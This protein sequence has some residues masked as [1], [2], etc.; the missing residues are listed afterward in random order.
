MTPARPVDVEGVLDGALHTEIDPHPPIY[1]FVCVLLEIV[2]NLLFGERR[3]GTVKFHV[4]FQY[5]SYL[6]RYDA[7]S[8]LG[9]ARRSCIFLLHI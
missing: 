7:I 3:T 9:H 4:Y 2:T 8:G 5:I 1:L 6:S